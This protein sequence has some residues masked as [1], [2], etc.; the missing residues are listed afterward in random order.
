MLEI[1]RDIEDIC[2][3]AWLIN[4]TNPSG[5]ITEAV[6]KY[7]KVKCIGLC[8]VP[9]NMHY[10]AAKRLG[11]DPKELFCEFTGL[12]HL[13]FM[14]HAYYNGVDKLPEILAIDAEEG[15]V[16]NIDK[17]E[18]MDLIEVNCIINKQGAMPIHIGS[19][20]TVVRGLVEQVKMY[21]VLTIK[22]AVT[23][24]RTTAFLALLNNPLIHDV[25]DA[26]NSCGSCE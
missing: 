19:L 4:F 10:D 9:I 12:N 8:N 1:C 5:I 26:K 16:K 7:S 13:S 18:E 23:G 22:A 17:I 14:T 21:E 11:V 2:P 24:D 6:H 15:V 25:I 3:D 20:P